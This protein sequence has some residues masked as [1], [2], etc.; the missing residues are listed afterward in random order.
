MATINRP[1][2]GAYILVILF[3]PGYFLS[4]KRW[5]AAVVSAILLILSIPFFFVFGFGILIWFVNAMWAAWNLRY[6]LMNVHINAQAQ[7]IVDKA[8]ALKKVQEKVEA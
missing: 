3:P 7:A 4:R 5:I 6:E 8:E 1:S 2:F